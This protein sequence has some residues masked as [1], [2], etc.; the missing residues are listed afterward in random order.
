MSGM[1]TGVF[2]NHVGSLSYNVTSVS[3]H[4]TEGLELSC[5]GRVTLSSFA[6]M[7]S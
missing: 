2:F 4:V 1:G 5:D 7:M 6:E 3:Y